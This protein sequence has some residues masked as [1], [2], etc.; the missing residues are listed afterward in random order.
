MRALARGTSANRVS[1]SSHSGHV[2]LATEAAGYCIDWTSWWPPSDLDQTLVVVHGHSTRK[3]ATADIARPARGEVLDCQ[4]AVKIRS[5]TDAEAVGEIV[6][7]P[8]LSNAMDE[9]RRG[10]AA[11]RV[12]WGKVER[13]RVHRE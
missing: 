13:P 7:A 4:A 8:Y 11:G 10:G 5:R 9:H 6:V 12:Q 2:V 3:G 1:A